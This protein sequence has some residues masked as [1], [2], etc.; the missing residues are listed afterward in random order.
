MKYPVWLRHE[1]LT[2][3]FIEHV[4]CAVFDFRKIS[5]L[6]SLAAT[7]VTAS[8]RKGPPRASDRKCPQVTASDRRET[9]SDRREQVTASD[10]K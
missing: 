8:D 4:G 3:F 10:R 9:A 7:R 2:A 6:Q 5:H 1:V